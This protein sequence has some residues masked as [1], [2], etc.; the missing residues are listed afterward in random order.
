MT[1]QRAIILTGHFP[2]QKRRA[3]IP[4]LS[5][6][7]QENGWHVTFATL[8]YSWISQLRGDRRFESIEGMPIPGTYELG[9][10]LTAIFEYPPIHPFSLGSDWVDDVLEP[11]QRLFVRYWTARLTP[12]LKSADLILIESGPPLLLAPAL[13][14]LAPSV[15][16]VYRASDDIR[17]LG[18]PSYMGRAELKYAPLFDRISVA[19]PKLAQRWIGHPGLKIDPIGVPMA[20]LKVPQPDPYSAPRAQ[21][22]AVCAGT[23]LFDEHQVETIAS[24]QPDWRFHVIG[25]L[26]RPPSLKLPGNI[27][28]LGELSYDETVAYIR[29]ADLGLAIYR[30][31]PGVEYQTAQSNRILLYRYFGLPILG[32]RRLCDPTIPSLFGYDIEDPESIAEAANLASRMGRQPGDSSIPDWSLLCDRI[33]QTTRL[34]TA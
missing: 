21:V 3:N 15:P 16:M 23:T 27:H 9:P 31:E 2:V 32:P 25:R 11:L 22:E 19:S 34:A 4:W 1:Q 8:G 10:T 18:L 13:R 33:T 12:H 5:D 30:D 26:K 17:L 28:F 6:Q 7:L 24:Q 14:A 20:R 29:H